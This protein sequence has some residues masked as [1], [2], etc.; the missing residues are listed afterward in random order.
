MSCT[1]LFPR[2]SSGGRV[3]LELQRIIKVSGELVKSYDL[4][5]AGGAE[6]AAAFA[7]A[8]VGCKVCEAVVVEP[9]G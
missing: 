7:F 5:L 9:C 4:E 6:S 1:L 8:E 2:R 3:R